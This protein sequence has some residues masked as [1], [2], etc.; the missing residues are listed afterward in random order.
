MPA[1]LHVEP[2]AP[3]LVPSAGRFAATFLG[4]FQTVR[5]HGPCKLI[6]LVEN[7]RFRQDRPGDY[8][9]EADTF[10][11]ARLAAARDLAAQNVE[12]GKRPAL[13]GLI[14]R[15]ILRDQ[16]AVCRDW[17]GLDSFIALDL[18]PGMSLLAL[19][20]NAKMQP[21]YSTSDP[22]HAGA[23]AAGVRLPGLGVQ[24]V[25]DFQLPENRPAAAMVS[26]PMPF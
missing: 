22:G 20:G 9:M 5:L 16:L 1:N 23:E 21:Y 13:A 26:Q 6:R 24:I 14:V 10:F 4:G 7:P 12:E 2:V 8:W 18:P 15:F 17:S 25:I 11:Q 3:D 19:I